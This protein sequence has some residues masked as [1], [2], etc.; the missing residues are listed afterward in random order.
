MYHVSFFVVLAI[1]PL[2]YLVVP[3]ELLFFS[4][5]EP[6]KGN[7]RATETDLMDLSSRNSDRNNADTEHLLLST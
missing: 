6:D 4:L 7:E 5:T 1:K 3:P 2:S